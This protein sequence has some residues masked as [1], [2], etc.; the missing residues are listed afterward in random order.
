MATPARIMQAVAWKGRLV[1]AL[2]FVSC[3]WA[4]TPW[5]LTQCTGANAYFDTTAMACL[6][7]GTALEFRSGANATRDVL[8]NAAACGCV[9]GFAATARACDISTLTVCPSPVCTSCLTSGLAASRTNASACMP[10]GATTLG[11]DTGVGDCTCA[12][13]L[14]LSETT[15]SGA[16][17]ASKECL[18]CPARG[19][20]FV[21]PVGTWRG[22]SYAC[23]AC[24]DPHA[25]LSATGD[26]VC[27]A[28][29]RAVG[30]TG[31][32]TALASPGVAIS[33]VPAASATAILATY[34]EAA[35][36]A[37]TFSALQ[38]STSGAATGTLSGRSSRTLQ[39]YYTA[40]AV[41]CV[42]WA[43]GDNNA[44]CQALANL[45]VLQLYA[46][47]STVCTLFSALMAARRSSIAGFVGWATSLPFLYYASD[48]SAVATDA[49]LTRVMS[50]DAAKEPGTSDRLQFF[51]ASYALNGTFLGLERLANQLAY[52][53]TGVGRDASDT[54][55]WLTFGYGFK[56]SYTCD[57][58]ALLISPA[59]TSPVFYD[60]YVR[61][62]AADAASL[63]STAT[64]TTATGA[65]LPRLPF[66][67]YPV[68]VVVTNLRTAD[69]GQPNVNPTLSAEGNDVH[70]RRFTLA[71]AVTGITTAGERSEVLRYAASLRLTIR[72]RRSDGTTT[73]RPNTIAPPVLTIEYRERLS[74]TVLA[75]AAGT[76]MGADRIAF[77][78]EYV[79]DNTEYGRSV[80]A[81][82]VSLGMIVVG[83]AGV[84]VTAWIRMNARSTFEATL[85][86]IHIAKY[87]QYL[88]TT[89]APAFFWFLWA[90]CLYWLVFFK[91][92]TA[93]FAIL[94][95]NR[96]TLTDNEY[97]AFVAGLVVVFIAYIARM[98]EHL[99]YQGA[100]TATTGGG[101]L[102]ALPIRPPPPPPPPACAVRCDVFFLD[103][104]KPR[105]ALV[106]TG[107]E[108]EA[109]LGRA[110]G[111]DAPGGE[112]VRGTQ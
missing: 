51:L 94:P 83:W 103:W 71:D 57:L 41:R 2:A 5:A 74:S 56:A 22:D 111:R 60:L 110:P 63:S 68:S 104:E 55:P 98:L 53:G 24:N 47:G 62:L 77:T 50:F 37:V 33:C 46:A 80:L 14:V 34:P 78:V 93:V 82:A 105:G 20:V 39:H 42:T 44:G 72:A 61:D 30:V 96:P 16:A 7:C 45:C 70:T 106:R 90:M 102:C 11:L 86:V 108:Y 76:G 54:P 84:R 32:T 36:I 59:A 18:A 109:A 29:F 3:V 25:T 52:C 112:S 69:G 85:G 38:T 21:N 43:A 31:L 1:A 92:Q 81:M 9:R 19:R 35:A 107:Q 6:P 26:C 48:S 99:A 40:A 67:L 75:D 73:G 79:T 101:A 91:L 17:L 49:A 27:D 95:L 28:G 88:V 100:H 12:A 58:R 64:T 4:G 15:A 23:A 97:I 89:F 10:C 8:G 65:I 87:F 66:T 13:G